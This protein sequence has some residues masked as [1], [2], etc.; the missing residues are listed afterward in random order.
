[1]STAPVVKGVQVQLGFGGIVSDNLQME[2]ASDKPSARSKFLKDENNNRCTQIISNV[3][4]EY[5]ING[6]ILDDGS[7]TEI[8]ALRALE[9]GSLISV[10]PTGGTAQK[11][12]ITDL[13]LKYTRTQAMGSISFRYI[14]DIDPTVA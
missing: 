11:C 5:T 12:T 4:R 2:D 6:V 13:E 3:G 8:A 14:V 10:T 9:V 7:H 1:M